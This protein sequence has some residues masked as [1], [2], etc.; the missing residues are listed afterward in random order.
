[1]NIKASKISIVLLLISSLLISLLFTGCVAN[2]KKDNTKE[3]KNETSQIVYCDNC[4]EPSNEITKYCSKCGKEAK[5]LS[6]KPSTDETSKK[7]EQNKEKNKNKEQV[8]NNYNT[9]ESTPKQNRQINYKAKYL[10][11]LSQLE[12]IYENPDNA[13]DW[14]TTGDAAQAEYERYQAWDDMLNEIYSLLKTQLSSSEMK[15]LKNEE[16][17]WIN[18]RDKTAENDARDFDGGSNYSVVYNGS[19]ATTTKD[20]C[21]ELVNNYMK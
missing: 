1:M 13:Y 20:R 17:N 2:F 18:Y 4:G 3:S 19:L 7:K 21:Y 9:S 8:K 11:K 5:W 6:D 15:A 10:S 16:I 12:D 14:S